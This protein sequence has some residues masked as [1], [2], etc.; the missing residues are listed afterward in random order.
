M[1]Y[2]QKRN[3][4]QWVKKQEDTILFVSGQ[5]FYHCYNIEEFSL[6]AILMLTTTWMNETQWSNDKVLA[7]IIGV[8]SKVAL[9]LS[10]Q[11]HLH[12]DA[13]PQCRLV[14]SADDPPL[15]HRITSSQVRIIHQAP[16]GT[17]LNDSFHLVLQI[18]KSTIFF[19]ND[20]KACH[21]TEGSIVF[22]VSFFTRI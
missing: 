10:L 12:H 17:E 8:C 3:S 14:L 16:E 18:L 5:P 21:M 20:K 1:L 9:V 22:N 7:T 6:A 4:M 11:E 19:M 15:S 13:I 2:S